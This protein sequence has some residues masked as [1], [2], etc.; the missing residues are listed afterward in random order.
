LGGVAWPGVPFTGTVFWSR[1]ATAERRGRW[2][3]LAAALA[4]QPGVPPA[5][6]RLSALIDAAVA[7]YRR[8]AGVATGA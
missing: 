7:H 8:V 4:R 2:P 1:I 5:C 6:A 3:D